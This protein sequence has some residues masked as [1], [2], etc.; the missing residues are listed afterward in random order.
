MRDRL[1]YLNHT[2]AALL[3]LVMFSLPVTAAE[4]RL[5]TLFS[6]LEGAAPEEAR[7]IASE[8]ELEWA[9]SGSPAMDL[10]LRRGKD[11][12]EA[13]DMEM[14]VEHLSAAID[15]AP[16]FAEAWHLRSV[17]FFRREHYGLALNDL[18]QVLALEPRHFNALF[19]MGRVFEETGRA[20]LA[21]E[22]FERSQA[23]HPHHE[24][25]SEAL[26][27]VSREMGGTDL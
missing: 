1:R 20:A 4:T 17:A 9:K 14:A 19:G 12:L 22:A 6:Q 26:E 24:A 16:G 13:D 27:R 8:I 10:L 25:V 3:A 7:R 5:D 23:I 11:A 15:H 18:A 21:H 2:V